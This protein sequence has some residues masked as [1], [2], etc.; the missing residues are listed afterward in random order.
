MSAKRARDTET[1]PDADN[2]VSL[3]DWLSRDALSALNP[4]N[5]WIV[6]DVLDMVHT[7]V[8]EPTLHCFLSSA[9]DGLQVCSYSV[10]SHRWIEQRRSLNATH[11]GQRVL[12]SVPYRDGWYEVLTGHHRFLPLTGPQPPG[13]QKSPSECGNVA[14]TADLPASRPLFIFS[15]PNRALSF[16]T[17]NI[18]ATGIT[19]S[20]DC[21]LTDLGQDVATI[22]DACGLGDSNIMLMLR[23][24]RELTN[25]ALF[26][27]HSERAL[28][29]GHNLERETRISV[30]Y[31]TLLQV[32]PP[33]VME[34]WNSHGY[35]VARYDVREDRWHDEKRPA[36]WQR[37]H[38]FY[39]RIDS[40]CFASI[41][42]A[43]DHWIEV[44]FYDRRACR[45]DRKPT[46]CEG[47]VHG[48]E[49]PSVLFTRDE[50]FVS[51]NS[52]PR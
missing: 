40:D 49:I 24:V 8:C 11:R 25:F 19:V 27:M 30:S 20:Q 43:A 29:M 44:A 46:D 51:V 9:L 21:I 13:L 31:A 12:C 16:E 50:P 7:R 6:R 52:D 41:G 34:L 4:H 38:P 3:V 17:A 32:E 10:S 5:G 14:L 42:S 47:P 23:P 18:A 36:V 37:F 15:A 45:W 33:N 35:L 26:D 48:G 39:Q 1:P 22:L 2:Q 28:S